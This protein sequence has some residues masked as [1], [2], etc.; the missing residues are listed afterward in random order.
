MNYGGRN[1]SLKYIGE[2][3]LAKWYRDIYAKLFINSE[4]SDA[5]GLKSHLLHTYVS[6]LMEVSS[7]Y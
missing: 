7:L 5:F 1:S 6:S 3:I 4:F 2:K